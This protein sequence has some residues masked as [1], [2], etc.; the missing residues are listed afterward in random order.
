MKQ[1]NK[2]SPGQQRLTGFEQQAAQESAQH[3]AREF[4]SPE[5]LL[6]ED[7]AQTRVPPAIAQR[8]GHSI[9]GL[10]QPRPRSWWQR[11]FGGS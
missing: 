10:P 1:Q 4:A 2:F 7:A 9:Q 6:R 3:A 8:I 11:L 5:E